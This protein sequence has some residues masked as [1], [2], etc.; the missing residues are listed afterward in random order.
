MED[1]DEPAISDA[2]DLFEKQKVEAGIAARSQVIG[3]AQDLK[4]TTL[5]VTLPRNASDYM[6][7]STIKVHSEFKIEACKGTSSKWEAITNSNLVAPI[8]LIGKSIFK[9]VDVTL[10]NTRL[11]LAAT[12]A[13]HLRAYL[14]TICSYGNDAA[15]THLKASYY[16]KDDVGRSNETLT[17]TTGGSWKERK[18][19][20]VDSNG[21]KT[22]HCCDN[23]HSEIATLN[24][25]IPSGIDLHLSFVLNDAK[26]FLNAADND[27]VEEK[28]WNYRLVFERF[29]VTMDVVTLKEDVYNTLET[30]LAKGQNALFNM[31][32]STIRTHPF[33][34]SNEYIQWVGAYTGLLPSNILV[35]IIDSEAL[36]GNY[37]KNPFHFEH[38]NCESL[39]LQAGTKLYPI[40]HI[41]TDFD[42]K[43]AIVAYRHLFDNLCIHNGN[44]GNQIDYQ[45]FMDGMTLY[46]F[47]L[48]TDLCSHSHA[49]EQAYGNVSLTIKLRKALTKN[50]T[51]FMMSNFKDRFIVTGPESQRQVI[52][53][54]NSVI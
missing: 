17:A 22:V 39:K 42:K 34:K 43:Q 14:E 47:D 3:V 52:L 35:G 41:E 38:A 7:T 2:L 27:L 21:A 44:L 37:K 16:V 13:Y 4:G 11:S 46:A 20:I 18:E 28:K 1:G 8:N 26:L 19:F 30:K 23:L 50:M 24:K 49:H 31:M 12:P 48:T 32:R 15:D 54:P 25:F 29:Y 36:A 51:V 5:N 45:S 40:N 10:N 9:K 33:L 6:D 53:N